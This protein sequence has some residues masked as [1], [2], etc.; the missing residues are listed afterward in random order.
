MT[1]LD[2]FHKRIKKPS[3]SEEPGNFSGPLLESPR[4]QST[5]EGEQRTLSEA[6]K[7]VF[8][9]A[10]L[11]ILLSAA[12]LMMVG[13]KRPL[14]LVSQMVM[15]DVN[16]LLRLKASA[17]LAEKGFDTHDDKN[18]LRLAE[19]AREI[20]SLIEKYAADRGVIVVAKGSVFGKDIVDVT[21]D[22]SA[23]L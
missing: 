20:R 21:D 11:A 23:L 12:A 7:R 18:S 4:F 22:L 6:Q 5:Q 13:L 14:P 1:L 17:L 16:Q 2:F 8:S 10:V 3:I 19:Q 15:V 9:L